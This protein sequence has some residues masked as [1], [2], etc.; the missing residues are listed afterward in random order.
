MMKHFLYEHHGTKISIND[1]RLKRRGQTSD[2]S[3]R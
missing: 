3:V 2:Y 1:K